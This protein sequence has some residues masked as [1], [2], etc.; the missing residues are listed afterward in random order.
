MKFVFIIK[1]ERR[2]EVGTAGSPLQKL[3]EE[4]REALS[5]NY[6][7]FYRKTSFHAFF[8]GR[9]RLVIDAVP[10]D[11]L[12]EL[13]MRFSQYAKHFETTRRHSHRWVPWVGDQQQVFFRCG[14]ENCTAELRIFI[15]QPLK[16]MRKVITPYL[17]AEHNYA[18]PEKRYMQVLLKRGGKLFL[19]GAIAELTKSLTRIEADPAK[20]ETKKVLQQELNTYYASLC[21]F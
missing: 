2:G 14:S 5:T 4:T 20:R 17:V 15:N 16:M 6:E 3:I 13:K 18:P 12:F 8:V 1:P 10:K 9:S 19:N 21:L 11:A 7:E